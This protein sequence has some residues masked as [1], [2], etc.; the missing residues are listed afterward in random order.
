MNRRNFFAA[1]TAMIIT[2]AVVK[3]DAYGEV[4]H[5][6]SRYAGPV[7]AFTDY[8]GVRVYHHDGIAGNVPAWKP[9]VR[10]HEVL[11]STGIVDT[12]PRQTDE[13]YFAIN[14]ATCVMTQ[15]GSVTLDVM[16]SLRGKSIDLIARVRE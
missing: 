16:K 11:I 7:T 13:G 4:H 3:I 12:D 2:P 15:P 9:V 10:T 1:I 14:N 8:P 5:G 6:I